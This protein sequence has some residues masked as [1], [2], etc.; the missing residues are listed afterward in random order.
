MAIIQATKPKEADQIDSST[1]LCYNCGLYGH[2]ANDCKNTKN[3]ELVA[4]VLKSQGRTLCMHCGRFGH[5]QA[6]CWSLPCNTVARPPYWR[7]L[8][9]GAEVRMQT[10]TGGHKSG[11]MSIDNDQDEYSELS[12]VSRQI[13]PDDILSIAASLKESGLSLLDPNVWIGDTGATTRN[14]TCIKNTTNHRTANA[15][16]NI[17][18]VMGVPAEAKT[19]VDVWCEF[20]QGGKVT[21]IVLR[22]VAYVPNSC[23]NLFSLTK[24]MSNRWCMAGDK[25]TGIRLTKGKHEI[26]FNRTVHTPK[27]VLYVIVLK[28]HETN[29]LEH[30]EKLWWEKGVKQGTLAANEQGKAITINKAH[31]MCS[32]M[33]QVEARAICD[34]F[35]Q[36]ITKRGYQQCMSCGKA[37]AKQLPIMQSNKE[38]EV[39]GQEGHCIFLDTSS[40][41][42]G[43]E[44]KKLLSKP[45][46]LLTVIEQSN[47]ACNIV[48]SLQQ[49]GVKVKFV[50]LDNAGEN[51]AFAELANSKEWNL[52]LT[53]EFT[54]ACT[55]QRNYLAEVGFVTLWGRL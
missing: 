11:A 38:H 28:Q 13:D 39:A 48:R 35:G 55:P 52:K 7:V 6:L 26:T 36:E 30:D 1:M 53:F 23:Y 31:A 25:K 37:K 51:F 12:L 16:D 49:D 19:I 33:G 50:Q 20:E 15:K 9:I 5:P 40:V 24:L 3:F 54:G 2:Q 32:H 18:G 22:D 44:T 4:Q 8:V 21:N 17:V 14:T 27:G 34:Y 42:H 46:W 29:K 43:S 10:N 47:F 45:Y 41:K